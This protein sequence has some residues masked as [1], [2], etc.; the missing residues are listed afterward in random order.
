VRKDCI[1]FFFLV[2]VDGMHGKGGDGWKA[3]LFV[4]GGKAGYGTR[5]KVSYSHNIVP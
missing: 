5:M 3:R 2:L 4:Y 1:F